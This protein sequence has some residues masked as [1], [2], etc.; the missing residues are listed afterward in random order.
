M[1][2][3]NSLEAAIAHLRAPAIN[4]NMAAVGMVSSTTFT[5]NF[6]SACTVS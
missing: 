2:K 4:K 1:G 5:P 6:S 3:P